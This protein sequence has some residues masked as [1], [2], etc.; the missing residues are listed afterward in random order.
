MDNPISN[1]CQGKS[2]LDVH[3]KDPREGLNTLKVNISDSIRLCGVYP[4]KVDFSDSIIFVQFGGGRNATRDGSF[5]VSTSGTIKGSP[6]A[7]I[8]TS[9]S[10]RNIGAQGE[11]AIAF[12]QGKRSRYQGSIGNNTLKS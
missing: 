7:C 4:S 8:R 6:N 9:E 10:L 12:Q 11:V 1:G 3:I 5:T 2:R